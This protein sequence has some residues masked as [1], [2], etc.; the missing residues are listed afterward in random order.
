M[1]V[2]AAPS[3]AVNVFV[4]KPMTV[5]TTS[6]FIHLALLL[7]HPYTSSQSVAR[8]SSE[9]LKTQGKNFSSHTAMIVLETI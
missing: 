5:A 4:A 8:I 9:S 2:I 6:F 1:L 7:F 3:Y